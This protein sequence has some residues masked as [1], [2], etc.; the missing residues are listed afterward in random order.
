MT[1]WYGGLGPGLFALLQAAVAVDFFFVGPGTLFRFA[2]A[3]EAAAFFSFVAGW[4]VVCLSAD[5]V[6]RQMHHDRGLRAAAES[7]TL[8]AKRLEQLTAALAQARTPRSAIEAAVQE[9]LHALKADAGMLVLTS[10]DGAT[11]EVA[12]T[13]A[14]PIGNHQ[15]T[16]ALSGKDPISDAVGRGAP[17]IIESR[18]AR[19][20]EY[21]DGVG[22]FAERF[23]ATVAVPLLI[24]SRVVGVV[25]LDFEAARTF[26][27][28]DR[29]YLSTLATYAPRVDRT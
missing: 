10:R 1:A 5:F 28:D 29:E 17:V 27:R 3:G 8:Q 21:P 9:P 24:G 26:T 2:S 22:Y 16:V 25:Q 19:L 13:V 4:L 14:H 6:F 11:A 20:D 23:E 7:A 12:R 15:S 18:H